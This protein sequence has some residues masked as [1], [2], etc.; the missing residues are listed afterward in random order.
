MFIIIYIYIYINCDDSNDV[1]NEDVS[2][3]ICVSEFLW[4]IYLEIELPGH[5]IGINSTLFPKHS[6]DFSY[7]ICFIFCLDLL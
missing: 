4:P 6:S 7:Q 3:C 5:R 1:D 2:M